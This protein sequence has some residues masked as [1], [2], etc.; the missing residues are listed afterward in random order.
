MHSDRR[1]AQAADEIGRLAKA[2]GDAD[3][4]QASSELVGIICFL[5]L[6]ISSHVI[7]PSKLLACIRRASDS[8]NGLQPE[9][10]ERQMQL[11]KMKKDLLAVVRTLQQRQSVRTLQQRQSVRTLQQRQSTHYADVA[12][13]AIIDQNDQEASE[14]QRLLDAST[15]RIDERDM[16]LREIEGTVEEV[17]GIFRD[18]QT[19]VVA[20]GGQIDNIEANLSSVETHVEDGTAHLRSARQHQAKARSRACILLV[21][22]LIIVGVLV[23]VIV[24]T[25]RRK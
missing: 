7:Y 12:H 20:Q 3:R 17:N 14:R 19:L 5:L 21:I 22:L 23:V 24:T 11:D 13:D 1:W 16:H 15:R 8:L 6:S 2:V 18:L 9:T 25:T 10:P 4:T